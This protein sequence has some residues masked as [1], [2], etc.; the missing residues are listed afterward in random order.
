MNPNLTKAT[1]FLRKK[2]KE[3]KEETKKSEE[4]EEKCEEKGSV[5]MP[6]S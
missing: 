2:R 1:I 6:V 5:P 4:N 3:E